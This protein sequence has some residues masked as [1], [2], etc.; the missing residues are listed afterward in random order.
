M[1]TTSPP[2]PTPE[3]SHLE[4]HPIPPEAPSPSQPPTLAKLG[5]PLKMPPLCAYE[6][7]LTMQNLLWEAFPD[8]PSRPHPQ[9]CL[10]ALTVT[11]TLAKIYHLRTSPSTVL[12]TTWQSLSPCGLPRLHS[13]SLGK[14]QSR[15]DEVLFLGAAVGAQQ[16]KAR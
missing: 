6:F 12:I 4:L 10:C 2:T 5:P 1:L 16:S 7:P 9:P 14:L 13:L 11:L 3:S 8:S 15:E